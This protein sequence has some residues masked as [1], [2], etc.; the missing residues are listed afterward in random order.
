MR[1]SPCGWVSDSIGK[2]RF[3]AVRSAEVTHN[4][5]EGIKGARATVLAIML[6]RQGF[7]QHYLYNKI[8]TNYH[9]DLTKT[10]DE[11]REDY[12]FDETCQGTVPQ[13]MVCAFDARD[14]E[15]AIRNAISI[16]GDSDTVAAIAGSIAEAIYGVPDDIREKALSY[17]PDDML[18]VV[19]QFADLQRVETVKMTND[20]D[21]GK[22]RANKWLADN[23]T[24]VSE[25]RSIVLSKFSWNSEGYVGHFYVAFDG[26]EYPDSFSFSLGASDGITSISNSTYGQYTFHPISLP[27][28]V[29]S[30][31]ANEI[32]AMFP[33]ITPY[34]RNRKTKIDVSVSTPIQERIPDP[35]A[36][37]K[38]I[39]TIT[40]PDFEIRI[41]FD[42]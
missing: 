9:Y 11:I 6:A 10:V 15:D 22:Q 28:R 18:K 37:S 8:R 39:E 34:G 20:I 42:C 41:E 1:V 12:S 4:H 3:L 24:V 25:V 7:N 35:G 36:L 38:T 33:R 21:S 40:D 27:V 5:P 23:L 13:A 30:A 19:D 29:S 2:A 26:V 17:L 16:G 31:I 32:L 14:F